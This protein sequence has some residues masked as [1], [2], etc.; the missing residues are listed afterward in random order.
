MLLLYIYKFNKLYIYIYIYIINFIYNI[1]IYNKLYFQDVRGFRCFVFRWATHKHLL[2]TRSKIIPQCPHKNKYRLKI[3]ASSMTFKKD[4]FALQ[5]P[6]NV[7]RRSSYQAEDC[8]VIYL[9]LWVLKRSF[10]FYHCSIKWLKQY[11]A[12]Y[13]ID[14]RKNQ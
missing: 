11:G 12:I 14:C 2:N 8:K 9:K 13:T 5:R 4:T 6:C 3:S 10:I 1:C 7:S